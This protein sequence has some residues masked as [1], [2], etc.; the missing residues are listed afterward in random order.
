MRTCL[1][2]KNSICNSIYR[3]HNWVSAKNEE[4]K[5]KKRR[6]RIRIEREKKGMPRKL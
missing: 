5:E 1:N 6:R 2:F 4:K 3:T